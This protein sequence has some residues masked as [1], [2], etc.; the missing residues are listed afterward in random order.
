MKIYFHTAYTDDP[1]E[2]AAIAHGMIGYNE[3]PLVTS[4][5]QA[6]Y[7]NERQDITPAEAGA[8]C[9]CSMNDCW[10]QFDSV[11]KELEAA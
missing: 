5:E 10:D 6:D 7:W 1:Q 9:N 11:V 3:A 2:F 4:Q 8:A